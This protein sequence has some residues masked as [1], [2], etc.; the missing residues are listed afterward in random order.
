MRIVAGKWRGRPLESPP[1]ARTRPTGDRVRQSLFDM[2]T[3]RV[4]FE[5]LL[6][7]D[8]F[9]GTGALGLEALSRGAAHATFFERDATSLAVVKRNVQKLQAEAQVLRADATRPPHA[10][11]ACDLVFLDPP[12]AKGLLATSVPALQAAG[13][14]ANDALLVAEMSSAAPE[15]APQGFEVLDARD[16]GAARIE[17]W[18][19]TSSA[20]S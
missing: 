14:F 7:L 15:A 12:Y 10:A 11:T 17:L 8:A 5:R 4:A 3:H 18:S 20:T 19:L 2:L 1:D 6:V 13:W 16:Y 9:A